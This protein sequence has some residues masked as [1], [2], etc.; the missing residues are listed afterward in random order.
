LLVV[1]NM[2]GRIQAFF[3]C[4]LPLLT[5]CKQPMHTSLSFK[6]SGKRDLYNGLPVPVESLQLLLFNIIKITSTYAFHVYPLYSSASTQHPRASLDHERR[7]IFSVIVHE[8]HPVP[9]F[10]SASHTVS[11]CFFNIDGTATGYTIS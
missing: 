9:K 1:G 10:F 4:R 11:D 5:L 3:V 2:S 8:Y 6:Y 7:S